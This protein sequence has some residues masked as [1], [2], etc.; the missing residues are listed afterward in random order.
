MPSAGHAAQPYRCTGYGQPHATSHDDL[1]AD[2]P[3]QEEARNAARTRVE[4][5][6]LQRKGRLVAADARLRDPRP[7]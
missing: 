3:L 2:T 5:V 7:K 4:A 1:D 6:K